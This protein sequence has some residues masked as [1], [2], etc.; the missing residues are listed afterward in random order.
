MKKFRE[1]AIG[2]LMDE[3]ERAA[4][5]LKELV[6]KKSGEDFKKILDPNTTD[7]DCRSIQTIIAHVVR[8]GYGYANSIRKSFGS[9]I[10]KP[11]YKIDSA[12]DAIDELNK[13]LLFSAE[14]LE[15]KW[16]M[17]DDE[18]IGTIVTTNWGSRLD[19]EAMLEH[20]IVH[21]LRHRR[22]IEKLT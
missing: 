19:I 4:V 12:A 8:S 16:K 9:E 5:D 6:G 3:Y 10:I 7:E 22:Q 15:G 21:I 17:A 18:I 13:M 14:T 11:D 20:A 1:G 2:A